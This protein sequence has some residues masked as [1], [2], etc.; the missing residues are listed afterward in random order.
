MCAGLQRSDEEQ[1][2]DAADVFL[3]TTERQK[4]L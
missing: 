1:Q 2:G 4:K 3:R